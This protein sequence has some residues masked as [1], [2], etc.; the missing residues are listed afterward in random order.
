M[1][2]LFDYYQHLPLNLNPVAFKL[3]VFSV[4]WYSLMYLVA[5]LTVYFLLR[6]RINREEWKIKIKA[7]KLK[8]LNLISDFLIYSFVGLIIGARIGEV[9]FYNFSYY[10][11]NP[12]A[13][14]SP[15]DLATH[16]FIGIYGMSY[17]GGLVGVL[18]AVGVFIKKYK[19]NFWN[20]SDFIIPAVPAGYFFGR[21]GNF[22][23]NELYGRVTTKPWGMYFR[24]YSF[25]LRYPSQLL[26]AFTEGILLF[27]I[28]WSMRNKRLFPGCFLS[29]YLIGYGLFRFFCEFFREPDIQGGLL[30]K[31]ITLGQWFSI[32]MIFSGLIIVAIRR[33]N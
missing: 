10:W 5:F 14:I 32:I 9:L 19:V 22:I 24:D 7:Q 33:K 30:L 13:I 4:S 2:S 15:F 23:N 11:Q 31:Y 8:S 26:E 28:L 27:V 12:L 3:G 1:N 18:I 20:L 17:H 29:L 25:E 21:I 16:K 6:Y